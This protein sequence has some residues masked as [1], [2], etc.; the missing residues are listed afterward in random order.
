M[1]RPRRSV[2]SPRTLHDPTGLVVDTSD[3]QSGVGGGSI[4]MA[5]AGSG[6]WTSLP[7]TLHRKPIAGAFQRQWRERSRTRSRSRS[8]DNV[9]NCASATRTVVLPVRTQAISEVSL[10]QTPGTPC[11]GP[12]PQHDGVKSS[13]RIRHHQ[14]SD[15]GQAGESGLRIA[16]DGAAPSAPRS[17]RPGATHRRSDIHRQLRRTRRAVAVSPTQTSNG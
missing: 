10:E 3:T 13:A 11:A 12:R 4:E 14:E 17:A 8:C 2:S 6:S 16:L 1:R 5:P 9:G 7:T 15:V